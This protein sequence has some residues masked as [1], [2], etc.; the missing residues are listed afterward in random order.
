MWIQEVI[1]H[2]RAIADIMETEYEKMHDFHE[3]LNPD[4]NK[5]PNRHPKLAANWNVA[6]RYGISSDILQ[7]MA[8]QAGIEIVTATDGCGKVRKF[9]RHE[10][11]PKIDELMRKHLKYTGKPY[12]LR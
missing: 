5:E 8:E 3:S 1:E 12:R 10:D 2:L 7:L 6:K 11:I 9:Y 4:N